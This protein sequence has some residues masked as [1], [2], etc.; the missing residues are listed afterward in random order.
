M[1]GI[2]RDINNLS[3]VNGQFDM[4]RFAV[5]FPYLFNFYTMITKEQYE[6]RSIR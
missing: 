4:N 3:S 6:E 5:D 1:K 2:V